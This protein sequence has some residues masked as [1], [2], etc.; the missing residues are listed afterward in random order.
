MS[1]WVWKKAHQFFLR[2]LSIQIACV[3]GNREELGLCFCEHHSY[4]TSKDA[5]NVNNRD[6]EKFCG[7]DNAIILCSG[8]KIVLY[9][10]FVKSFISTLWRVI[11][12]MRTD[13]QWNEIA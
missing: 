11:Y 12:S 6:K 7:I 9:F 4:S 5:L 8:R 3:C 2:N 1:E 13:S 10:F